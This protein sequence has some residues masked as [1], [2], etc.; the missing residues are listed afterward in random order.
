MANAAVG[1][2]V[3]ITINSSLFNQRI[4][5]TFCY[6]ISSITGTPSQASLLAALHAKVTAVSGLCETFRNCVPAQLE[7]N[8]I[9][10]QIIAP[11]RY[12]KYQFTTGLG[13]GLLA[14]NDFF[15]ANQSAVILRRGELGGR[16]A[17]STLHI[18]LGQTPGCQANGALGGD[19]QSPLID[20]AQFM[21]TT[22]TTTGT[23]AAFVPVI[24]NG[25][26]LGDL[27]PIAFT[28]VMD[29]VRTM[30]RRGV[31]LGI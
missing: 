29:N 20:M 8:S 26:G 23:V 2:R 6:G 18:P 31:G 21:V 7:V 16:S 24:N 15:S 30:R 22:I 12:A 4:M 27:T 19:V 28:T 3:L 13:L 1:D 17:V 5:S 10:Y 25:P 14:D 11:I 9:W